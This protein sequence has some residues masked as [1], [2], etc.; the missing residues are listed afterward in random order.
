MVEIDSQSEAVVDVQGHAD[1]VLAY[2]LHRTDIFHNLTVTVIEGV[3]VLEGTAPN[4]NAKQAL[5]ML[6]YTCLGNTEDEVQFEN[7]LVV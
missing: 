6:T 4:E 3:I 5:T 7:R 1:A 2:V